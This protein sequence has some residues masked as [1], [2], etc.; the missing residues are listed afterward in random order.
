VGNIMTTKGKD[1][2][3]A[4]YIAHANN[5]AGKWYTDA[6]GGGISIGY[7]GGWSLVVVYDL[8]GTPEAINN[9][10][11]EAYKNVSL[12]NGYDFFM[13][14]GDGD[15]EF[16]ADIALSGF[17]TPSTGTVDSK[18]L[19]FGGGG[20]KS[21]AL[22]I[23]QM[24]NKKTATFAD[25]SD[26]SNA[27]NNQFNSTHVITGNQ[28]NPA[29]TNHEGMDLDVFD[30]SN[31]MDH[32]Q[33]ST[34]I[35]F[36]TKKVHDPAHPG[37]PSLG[38]GDQVFPQVLGFSTELYTPKLC[39]DYD[40]RVGKFNK[41]EVGD[42]RNFTTSA[43]G[44]DPLTF[45]VM[46]KSEHADFD[47]QNTRARIAFT[48]S[49]A[50]NF[51]L[52]NSTYSPPSTNAYLSAIGTS[53]SG[54]FIAVGV[55]AT[56]QGG[57]ISSNEINYAK[58]QY[59]FANNKEVND[60]FDVE[61]RTEI[62]FA[63]GLS[64]IP[65]N[66]TSAGD[67]NSTTHI[68]RCEGDK[69]YNPV[70]GWF[71]VE[72]SDA[73]AGMPPKKRYP[74]YTQVAGRDF[75]VSLVSYG[76]P[77]NYDTEQASGTTVELELINAET[78]E[79]NN[80]NGFDSVCQ[81]QDPNIII[82]KGTLFSFGGQKR[83]SSIS[84]DSDMLAYPNDTALRNAAFRIWAFVKTDS[85][86]TKTI[87]NFNQTDKT[88]FQHVYNTHFKADDLNGS[89]YCVADCS[90]SGT[91]TCY[92]CLKEYFS[93]PI[94]SRDNFAI[95]PEGFRVALKDQGD[96]NSSA[97]P[98]FISDNTGNTGISISAGYHTAL[99][100]KLDV[101]ETV[102][103]P[104]DTMPTSTPTLPRLVT[105]RLLRTTVMLQWRVPTKPIIRNLSH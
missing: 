68:E 10:S 90:S 28:L 99:M 89:K 73:T 82:G 34:K 54:D 81:N 38:S 21:L 78:F 86:G 27:V 5:N 23:L 22:D 1:Y 19:F 25:I 14:W 60:I 7:F 9:A 39:Y 13:T 71:N 100:R 70:Y 102:A 15:V 80:S 31:Y 59:Q 41:V 42:D 35:R 36:G 94:C 40:V 17:K 95:R 91:T 29:K 105:L 46:L 24:Q 79:N 97:T 64:A 37:D 74:L 18:L 55:N 48:G 76:N 72:R 104:R 58:Y 87:V 50:L 20:D 101:L 77:P 11:S 6:N 88:K 56:N 47:L 4:L 32:K 84:M 65:Y 45:H 53:D 44:S 75:E 69:T 12:Y 49:P 43:V 103:S 92:E 66:L 2:R 85:N 96:S 67:A 98:L 83:I 61:I 8:L 26:G 51:D 63:S 93:T 30:V 3:D 16:K 57:V 33:T 62:Q 52:A